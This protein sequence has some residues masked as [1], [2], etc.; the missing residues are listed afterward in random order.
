MVETLSLLTQILLWPL[1]LGMI[2][3]ILL[4]GGAGDLS[5]AFGG[6][7]MLDSTLGVGASRK[8]AKVTAWM[9][10]IFF[11]CVLFLAIPHKGGFGNKPG[12]S[13]Q[14]AVPAATIPAPGSPV[15]AP[16]APTAA[17]PAPVA[18]T[19]APALVPASAP[20]VVAPAAAV[21]AAP[22]AVEAAKAVEA[23]PADAQKQAEAAAAEKAA[24]AKKQADA[25]M[26][27]LFGKAAPL[28]TAD[29]VADADLGKFG[30][31]YAVVVKSQIVDQAEAPEHTQEECTDAAK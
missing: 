14:G 1:C 21:V 28:L 26:N 31:Y 16:L 24:E 7:G 25:L 2:G 17:A 4:Q 6:G 9:G 13:G 12:S 22:P 10:G 20:V 19:S 30:T 18:P 5:S 11:V 8:M 15:V 27:A 3:L 23:A 29:G